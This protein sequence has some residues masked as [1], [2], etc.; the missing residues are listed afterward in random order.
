MCG[1]AHPR[2]SL[3][4]SLNT[5]EQQ[6]LLTATMECIST[7]M[8]FH[9]KHRAVASPDLHVGSL[10]AYGASELADGNSSIWEK[11]VHF[12]KLCSGCDISIIF[13]DAFVIEVSYTEYWQSSLICLTNIC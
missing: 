3:R 12:F 6:A 7:S 8:R 5:Y 9:L 2:K 10:E 4:S 11:Y 1:F 13:C